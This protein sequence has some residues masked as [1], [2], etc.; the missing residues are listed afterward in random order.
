MPA[1]AVFLADDVVS[2]LLRFLKFSE[3]CSLS[4]LCPI[5]NGQW[6]QPGGAFRTRWE[7]LHRLRW[8]NDLD[9]DETH[10]A[11]DYDVVATCL[12]RDL[13]DASSFGWASPM[14]QN[15]D[16]LALR[17]LGS[18]NGDLLEFVGDHLKNN[19]TIVK[20]VVTKWGSA[21]RF[22]SAD[23]RSRFDVVLAAVR[24]WGYAIRFASADVRGNK[25][26]ALAAVESMGGAYRF[27]PR[28]LQEDKDV[29]LA[30]VRRDSVMLT[31]C[32]IHFRDDKDV[33]LAAVQEDGM[34]LVHASE[35]LQ[36]DFDVLLVAALT[37]DISFY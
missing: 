31:K 26:I 4:S 24:N 33:V 27:L 36:C 14:L 25:E 17:A 10:D 34:V 35:R 8:C 11:R 16:D 13:I 12:R 9:D 2:A 21:L 5:L 23:V 7:M 19:A 32:P 3:A 28:E 22:A 6:R 18:R 29:V 37:V 20:T 15:H 1:L 30:A